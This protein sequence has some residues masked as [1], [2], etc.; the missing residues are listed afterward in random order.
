MLTSDLEDE[1]VMLNIESSHYY[2][3]ASV[4]KFIWQE[5]ES[6]TT[7]ADLVDKMVA[8]FEVDR[9]TCI[10]E[11]YTFLEDLHQEGIIQ[12]ESQSVE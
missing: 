9:E 1:V 5:I 7:V 6:P 12:V 3:L 2:G 8:T 10:K 4:G 11:T